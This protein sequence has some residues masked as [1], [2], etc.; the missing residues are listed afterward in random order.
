MIRKFSSALG[1]P[2]RSSP[3]RPL[4][5]GVVELR[6]TEEYVYICVCEN[7]CVTILVSSSPGHY[8]VSVWLTHLSIC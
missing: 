8:T 3:Q 7:I 5:D 1:A 2:L 4:A 6:N